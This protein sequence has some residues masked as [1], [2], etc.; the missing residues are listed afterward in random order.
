MAKVI[1]DGQDITGDGLR[2]AV[3]SGASG[4]VVVDVRSP[5][6][7]AA[8]HIPGS[9]NLPLDA[10]PEVASQLSGLRDQTVALVCRTGM[11]ASQ[12]ESVL[13]NAGLDSARVLA[14]GIEG[15]ERAGLPLDRGRG[16]WSI[17]R[18]VRT[19]AGGLVVTGV[20]GSLAVNRKLLW[21]SGF[22]GGGLLFAGLTD[23]C[24]MAKLLM[25]LPYNRANRANVSGEVSRLLSDRG[26]RRTLP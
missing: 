25:L 2:E 17:E 10:L 6:E 20:I 9:Y 22:V 4:L 23:F 3:L 13:R 18:Q 19:I 26:R 24:G 15:W 8:A 21:L 7:F 11:R 5:G 14:G 1:G 16:T 12:A